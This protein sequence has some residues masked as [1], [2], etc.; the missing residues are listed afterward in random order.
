VIAQAMEFTI[1]GRVGGFRQQTMMHSKCRYSSI[2]KNRHRV[3]RRHSGRLLG[4][5]MRDLDDVLEGWT[6]IET[7]DFQADLQAIS[8]QERL[9]PT[10]DL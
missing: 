3:N 4:D 7:L 5:F 9:I 1:V 6:P 10:Y 8:L 2:H